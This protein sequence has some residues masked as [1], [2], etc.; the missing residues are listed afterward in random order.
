MSRAVSLIALMAC[1]CLSDRAT[2]AA[3]DIV[4]CAAVEGRV[5]Y[6]V[7]NRYLYALHLP[8]PSSSS[9]LRR[10]KPRLV[11]KEP[12]P[13]TSSVIAC[14]AEVVVLENGEVWDIAGAKSGGPK[15]TLAERVPQAPTS[16]Q[17]DKVD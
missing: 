14:G 11:T 9:I 2:H 17:I 4:Q 8:S 3:Q 15:W 12:V 1:L 6:A 10:E 7:V 5:V 16:D 13:G